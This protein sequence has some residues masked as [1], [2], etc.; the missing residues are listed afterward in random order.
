M[1]TL[2]YFR[3]LFVIA[4]SIGLSACGGYTTVTL[5]GS[6]VGLT[7]EVGLVLKI[8]GTT[9]TVTINPTD[10]TFVFPDKID[11]HGSYAV[12]FVSQ[13][14]HATC[15][16]ANASGK[17]TGV[18]VEGVAV[19]CAHNTWSL[20]GKVVGTN[21]TTENLAGLILANGSVQASPVL[22]P[23]VA[24]TATTAAVDAYFGFTFPAV[25]RE[26][27]AYSVV[28]LS[29]PTPATSALTCSVAPASS[30]TAPGTAVMGAA[31]V[32]NLKVNCI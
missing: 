29:Q 31:N 7:D 20:G 18:N 28:V 32:T 16:L 3:F 17:A 8:T 21:L 14:A 19:V 26:T 13:P 25:V 2:S 9:S 11:D 23:A 22:I 1:K 27:D 6:V 12:E 10:K 4:C 24:A 30:D 5:G 15:Y